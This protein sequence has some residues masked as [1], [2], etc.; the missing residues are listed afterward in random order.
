[1]VNYLLEQFDSPYFTFKLQEVIKFQNSNLLSYFLKYISI[2]NL[3][4]VFKFCNFFKYMES[5]RYNFSTSST[6]LISPINNALSASARQVA[7][8]SHFYSFAIMASSSSIHEHH[9]NIG[10]GCVEEFILSSALFKL[11]KRNDKKKLLL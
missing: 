9:A 6:G 3:L 8:F 10:T 2:Y 4:V 1:M 5:C 11:Q 7:H